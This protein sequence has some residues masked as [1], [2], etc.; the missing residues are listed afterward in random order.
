MIAKLVVDPHDPNVVYAASTGHV[1]APNPERGIFKT[2]DGGKTWRKVL[3]VDPGTGGVDLSMNERDPRVL[4][5]S[6]WQAQR[7]AWKL[8]SGGPG[9][10]LYK[11]TDGGAHWT[12]LSHNRG[13]AGG[14]LGKMGVSV[15]QSDPRI[16]YAIVQ[17]KDGG[18][19]RSDDAGRTW[20]HLNNQWKLR[21]RAFYYMAIFA[22]PVNPNR[23]YA[24]NVDAMY[25]S[26]NGGKTWNGLD[27]NTHGDHHIVW[28]NPRHTNILLEGNDGGA[29]VSVN[30]GDTFSRQ[31]NQPTGQIYHVALDRQFP[32][33]IFGASQDEASWEYTSAFVGGSIPPSELHPVALGESTFIAPDPDNPLVTFGSG[34]YSTFVELNRLTGQEENVSPWPRLMSG[35]AAAD[36]KYRF[37]WTHPVLFAPM[38]SQANS[39][40][41]LLVAEVVFSSL[42]RGRTWSVISPDLTRNDKSTQGLSGGPIDGDNTGAEMFPDISSL[43]V[44][45]LDRDVLWAGSSDGL[46]H[47]TVD[48]GAHWNAV[49]PPQLPQWS[50]ISSIEPS[51]VARG[52]AYLTA[53]RYQW[54][55]FHPYVYETTDFGAHWTTIVDGLPDN[56]TFTR[57]SC[58]KIRGSRG[59]CLPARAA[60]RT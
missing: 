14:I 34:Y 57:S 9:S 22:D 56:Q 55:D 46:V 33:H 36:L 30:R 48:H 19:F 53:S 17:A 31:D 8:E 1:W 39:H 18:V 3:Y 42:D 54:D 4:Y 41:L 37:S 27:G 12:N 2:T 43:N 16:V 21:Q 20:K 10:G 40:E 23:V 29:T 45:P 59:C 44:S 15:A 47:V 11:T 26:T 13:F 51:Y 35:A 7:F 6:M 49:T 25:A 32:F 50:Q 52:T 5:A 28:I 60:P 38:F 24:P 58:A